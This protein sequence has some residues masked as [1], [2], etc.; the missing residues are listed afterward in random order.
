[1]ECK[2]RDSCGT[3]GQVR[4]LYVK[5][6]MWLTACPAESEHLERKS[7]TSTSNKVCENSLNKQ[8]KNLA[9]CLSKV[10]HIIFFMVLHL[11]C[12]KFFVF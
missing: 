5:R 10:L 1:M 7:T 2:V 3:G 12:K 9:H 8:T 4:H 11:I 6:R